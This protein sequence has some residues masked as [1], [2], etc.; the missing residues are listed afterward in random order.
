M[1]EVETCS[2]LLLPEGFARILDII[3]PS[4]KCWLIWEKPSVG[5]A[6]SSSFTMLLPFSKKSCWEVMTTWLYFRLKDHLACVSAKVEAFHLYVFVGQKTHFRT[7][8]PLMSS[9]TLKSYLQKSTMK[10][11]NQ[12]KMIHCLCMLKSPTAFGGMGKVWRC[13]KGNS[14]GYNKSTSWRE[15]I[16][17]NWCS[18]SESER[19]ERMVG[20]VDTWKI[21]VGQR[22]KLPFDSRDYHMGI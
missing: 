16:N 14:I 21:Y 3:T 22:R 2:V 17:S 11:G 12:K 1:I 15:M 7:T 19:Q 13:Q 9:T 6:S 8:S 5:S 18:A 20:T 10:T 4:Q